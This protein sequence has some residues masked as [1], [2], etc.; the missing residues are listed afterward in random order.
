[1][2]QKS[3]PGRPQAVIEVVRAKRLPGTTVAAWEGETST[4]EL[5][6][7]SY[8]SGELG[9]MVALPTS[10]G[11]AWQTVL[12]CNTRLIEAEESVVRWEE[13]ESWLRKLEG[14]PAQ[15]QLQREAA[16]LRH[17]LWVESRGRLRSQPGGWGDGVAAKV[18]LAT[19][20]EWLEAREAHRSRLAR[21]GWL[22]GTSRV[23]LQT[24]VEQPLEERR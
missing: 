4:G 1:M 6:H 3:G 16:L 11:R 2:K 15:R 10:K 23:V 19:V 12:R 17:R 14:E 8:R 7:L 9:V 24:W 20:R 13:R 5:V 22:G 18:T 21:L